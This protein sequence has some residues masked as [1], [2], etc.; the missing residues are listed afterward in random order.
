MR[1]RSTRRKRR[2]KYFADII[3]KDNSTVTSQSIMCTLFHT[4]TRRYIFYYA[5][6]GGNC[7]LKMNFA[8]NL[9]LF[10][11]FSTISTSYLLYDDPKYTIMNLIAGEIECAAYNKT[12][13]YTF[14][15]PIYFSFLYV[16]DPQ[17]DF[18]Y[19]GSGLNRHFYGSTSITTDDGEVWTHWY[20]QEGEHEPE[21]LTVLQGSNTAWTRSLHVFYNSK[22]Y[23][24]NP[25]KNVMVGGGVPVYACLSH[26][27]NQTELELL[28][29]MIPFTSYQ[30][31]DSNNYTFVYRYNVNYG[32]IRDSSGEYAGY[33]RV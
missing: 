31:E 17:D 18:G 7:S 13:F 6:Y 32:E 5:C 3:I 1:I 8:P 2:S 24:E 33:G 22:I 4:F 9:T 29:D 10:L 25:A 23:T 28:E 21:M 27:T 11:Y 19:R 15:E 14:D 16:N 30:I 26:I 20:D 12:G